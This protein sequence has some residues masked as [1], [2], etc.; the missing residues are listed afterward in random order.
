MSLN[1]PVWKSVAVRSTRN[2]SDLRR[3]RRRGGG[4]VNCRRPYLVLRWCQRSCRLMDRV[5]IRLGGETESVM[6]QHVDTKIK[7]QANVI[8][9][10]GKA[11]HLT[12]HAYVFSIWSNIWVTTSWCD[13]AALLS[14]ILKALWRDNAPSE[15]T[16]HHMLP[17]YNHRESNPDDV[18]LRRRCN[19]PSYN[20]RMPLS[21]EQSPL[22][23]QRQTNGDKSQAGEYLFLWICIL[24]RSRRLASFAPLNH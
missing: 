22:Q 19:P 3:R 20:I 18:Y 12:Q 13:V 6:N 16:R 14:I 24:I 10:E 1:H 2:P 5:L 4:G 8:V 23:Q 9:N 17:T 7:R 11:F 21:V 15:S